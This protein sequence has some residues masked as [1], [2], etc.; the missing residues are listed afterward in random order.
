MN[1]SSL[2]ETGGSAD[3]TKIAASESGRNLRVSS[4]LRS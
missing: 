2:G 1:R 4:S 3:V